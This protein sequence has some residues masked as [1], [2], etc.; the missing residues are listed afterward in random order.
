M[1]WKTQGYGMHMIQPEPSKRELTQDRDHIFEANYTPKFET[2][3]QF[4]TDKIEMLR[5]HFR[6]NLT[7]EDIDYLCQFKTEN[8]IN[9]AVKG[10]INKY[11]E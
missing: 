5:E 3:G 8:E 4:I 6:I 1:S 9:A 10:I 7:A 11:W 2:P